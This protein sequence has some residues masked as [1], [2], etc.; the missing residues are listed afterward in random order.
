MGNMLTSCLFWGIILILLFTLRPSS[1]FYRK[2]MGEWSR[3]SWIITAILIALIITVSSFLMSVISLYNGKRPGHRN[4]Y[5]LITEAFLKGQLH[6]DYDDIDPKLLEMENPYNYGARKKAGVSFHWDHAFYNG[7][8]YMYYGVVPVFLLFMP[9]RLITGR[10]LTTYHATQVFTALTVIGLFAVFRFLSKKYMKDLPIGLYWVLSV[11]FSMISIMYSTSK[12]AL[13]QTAISS[14]V[15]LEIWSLFFFLKA[16]LD[17]EEVNRALI[18][19]AIGSLLG[20]LVFGCRPTVGLAN[21]VVLPLLI[22]FLNKHGL[23]AGVLVKTLLAATPYVIVAALLMW[24]NN[25]RFGNPFEFGQSYQLT[26][27][28]QTN[29][30]G[31]D[32]IFDVKRNLDGLKFCFLQMM[33]VKRKFPFVSDGGLFV[34]YPVLLYMLVGAVNEQTRKRLRES[35][36]A[37]WICT[38]A[39]VVLLIVVMSVAWTPRLDMRYSE[40]Y[41]WML[42]IIAFTV[43]GFMYQT[44]EYRG[45]FCARVSYIAFLSAGICVLVMTN[46][47]MGKMSKTELAAAYKVIQALSFGLI[48]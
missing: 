21:I 29:Y 8:Y 18:Y 17:T 38:I 14:G 47:M 37:G 39:A 46:R 41:I 2:T 42:C 3:G 12:P 35:G 40:D 43:I 25:A 36:L 1:N 23:S 27:T 16:V 48:H 44:M 6:F 26:V 31:L 34:M 4:Q 20:A 19:A 11:V 32:A 24:Y 30:S 7:K 10:P 45:N 9:Y 33:D 13:Y 28:D 22:I 5:E 15:C